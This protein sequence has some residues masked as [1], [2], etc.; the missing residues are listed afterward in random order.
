M[1]GRPKIGKKNRVFVGVTL[2]PEI[3]DKCKELNEPLS[4]LVNRL[5]QGYLEMKENYSPLELKDTEKVL[6]ILDMDI[7][8]ISSQLSEMKQQ[9]RMLEEESQKRHTA[10]LDRIKRGEVIIY[11]ETSS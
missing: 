3:L 7:N 10:L 11:D 1:V 4:S 5:L 8:K 9:K 6:D 2:D